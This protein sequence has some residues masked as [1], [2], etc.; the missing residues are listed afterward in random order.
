MARHSKD[1]KEMQREAQQ[2]LQK[3]VEE[4]GVEPVTAEVCGPWAASGQTMRASTT[5]GRR[6]S[7]PG[8]RHLKGGALI[9]AV[10][11]DTDVISFVFKADTRAALYIPHLADKL[12]I[13]SFMS[14]AELRQW[15]LV[16]NWGDRGKAELEAFLEERYIVIQSDDNLC[17]V[18]AKVSGRAMKH[19]RPIDSGLRLQLC[20]TA[21]L[22]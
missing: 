1:L 12:L 21:S 20:Y 16:R 8:G 19:G 2:R 6:A 7:K 3:L 18:W 10:A 14:L 17:S 5:S 22:W 9:D 15:A 4:R 13:A 11:V